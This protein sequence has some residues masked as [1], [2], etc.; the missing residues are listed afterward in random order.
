MLNIENQY[1]RKKLKDMNESLND[2][3]ETVKDY[4]IKK[5]GSNSSKYGKEQNHEQ[6]IR[7]KE[8]ELRNF[9]KMKSNLNG[10]L[11]KLE[12]RVDQVSNPDFIIDLRESITQ[13]KRETVALQKQKKK[14]VSDKSVRDNRMDKIIQ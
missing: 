11:L 12:L 6:K 2:F 5:Q 14:M 13:V 7:T 10:E 9:A 1:I 3:I 8:A 4:R